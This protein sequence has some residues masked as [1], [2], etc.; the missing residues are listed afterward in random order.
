MSILNNFNIR[1]AG[2][3]VPQGSSNFFS[4]ITLFNSRPAITNGMIADTG[5]T[6]GTEAAIAADLDSFREDDTA[7]GPLIRQVNVLDNSLNGLW[8]M[9][10]SQRVHRADQRDARTPTN[11]STLGGSTE[12][13]VLRAAPLRRAG[14][15]RGRPGAAGQHRRRDQL[16]HQPALYPAGRDDQVQHGQRPRR[17]NPGAS[18]N[19]GSRSYING[20]DQNNDYSPD[21]PGFVD[22]SAS[23]PK[24]SSPR[25]STTWRP[26]PWCPTRSMS[27]ARPPRESA[28]KLV[29]AA[30]GSVGIQSG[31]HRRHQRGHLPVRRR[32]GQHAR[33]SPSPRSRCWPSSPTRPTS[34]RAH[35]TPTLTISGTHVYITNNNFFNNFDAAMQIEPNGLMA[36]NPLTP[37][38]CDYRRLN[39]LGAASV[40]PRQRDDRTTASTA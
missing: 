23:D 26:R 10:E 37:L 18:L 5:G 9:S 13:H 16:D 2:G 27:P 35:L 39:Q 11:P 28:A 12:L 15:T 7:R 29:P 1:Y 20:F 31:A 30:W 21:S 19:V 32:R 36:G 6:G 14:A 22:E 3:A 24:C 17:L 25:S 40:L 8:L 34:L 33:T 38:A 4:A